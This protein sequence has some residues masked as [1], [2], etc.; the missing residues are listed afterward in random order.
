MSEIVVVAEHRRGELSPATFEVI[1]A[2][3]ELKQA[4]DMTVAVAVL[5]RDPSVFTGQVSVAGVDEVVNATVPV[6]EFQ[7]DIYETVVDGIIEARKPAVVLLSH[8]ID[9]W[10]YAPALAA[11]RECGFAADVFGLEF[12]GDELIATRSA[13][14]EKMHVELDFPGKETVLITLRGNVYKP[15]EG[16]S[17]PVVTSFESPTVEA[18][19]QHK[20][21]I[22]PESGGDVDI[23]QAEFMLS[24]GRGVAE[25]DNIE[26]F[27]ELADGMGFTLGCSR[28]IADSGWLP[29]S[30]QVGQSGKT[31][32]NCNI[33]LAFGISGSIQHMAGMKHVPTIIAV[34]TDAEASIFTVARYGVVADMFDI[35]EELKNHFV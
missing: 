17:T 7:N 6:S 30:R 28:P 31:V 29:K 33:Y 20:G 24:V 15:V 34:N 32:S 22:E 27:E 25:E 3:V 23:T 9:A 14:S 10:G 4:K 21:F 2:A 16:A 13:Y 12:D 26:Q 8:S 1:A 35:A 5:A 11:R 19:T 18:R